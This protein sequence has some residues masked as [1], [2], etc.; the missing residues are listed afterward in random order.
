MRWKGIK[1]I[2]YTT[3]QIRVTYKWGGKVLNQSLTYTTKQIRV[4]YKWGGKVLN[5]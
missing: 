1:S 3:K 5:Q 4:T 2:T